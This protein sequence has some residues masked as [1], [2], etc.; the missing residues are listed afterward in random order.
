MSTPNDPLM[1]PS[2]PLPRTIDATGW[3]TGL[4]MGLLTT[5]AM[6][7]ALDHLMHAGLAASYDT[8]I[9]VRTMW[10]LAHGASQ[11]PIL[12]IHGLAIHAN[13]ILVPMAWLLNWFDGVTMLVALQSVAYGLHFV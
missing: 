2:S 3:A 5:I 7:L 9:Y 1:A 13:W 10:G 6:G 4:V 8:A 11:N 12:N